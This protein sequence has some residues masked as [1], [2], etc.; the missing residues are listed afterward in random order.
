[1]F[2]AE[3]ITLDCGKESF[4]VENPETAL[5]AIEDSKGLQYRFLL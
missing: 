2:N 1:L 4:L 3:H 5:I